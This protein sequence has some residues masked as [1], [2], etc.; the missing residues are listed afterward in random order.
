MQ[1]PTQV[2]DEATAMRNQAE[3]AGLI[4]IS[5]AAD[6]FFI[7]QGDEQV[8]HISGVRTLDPIYDNTTPEQADQLRKVNA[9]GNALLNLM[10]MPQA[11]HQGAASGADA[12]HNIMRA[13]GLE[14]TNAPLKQG[15][16][17]NQIEMSRT[18]SFEDKMNAAVRWR[19]EAMPMIKGEIDRLLTKAYGTGTT[20]DMAARA[21]AVAKTT[22][23]QQSGSTL[24]MS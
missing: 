3:N 17:L 23:Y 6:K 21:N 19:D 12:I 24:P 8:H 9:S 4:G 1:Q 22:N 16:L 7:P 5:P 18:G 14:R 2:L 20:P 11:V 15:S 13:V 10:I